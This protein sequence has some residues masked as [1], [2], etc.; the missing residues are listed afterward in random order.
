MVGGSKPCAAHTRAPDVVVSPPDDTADLAGLGVA[1]AY[2]PPSRVPIHAH[3]S[4]R[5]TLARARPGVHANMDAL[6]A[7][8]P[9]RAPP[10]DRG[11]ALHTT[12]STLERRSRMEGGR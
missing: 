7:P 12:A 5:A 8:R 11:R 2:T 1:P 6:D 4:P 9:R 10:D 3:T